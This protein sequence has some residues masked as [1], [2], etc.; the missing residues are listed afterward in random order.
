MTVLAAALIG[1]LTAAG[2]W[3]F[4]T[5][6][7]VRDDGGFPQTIDVE[8]NTAYTHRHGRVRE[9]G[10]YVILC[11]GNRH[12]VPSPPLADFTL[13]A[14]GD[15]ECHEPRGHVGFSVFF[16][17]DRDSRTGHELS[18]RRRDA[19]MKLHVELDGRELAVEPLPFGEGA[20]PI[21]LKLAVAGR[22]GELT[23]FGRNYAFDLPTDDPLPAR[24]SVGFD[25]LSHHG[26]KLAFARLA[27]S[28]PETPA[29]VSERTYRFSLGA[30]QGANEPLAYDVTLRRYA[31]GETDLSAVL[32]GSS[33]GRGERMDSGGSSVQYLG[34]WDRVTDPYVRIDTPDGEYRNLYNFPDLSFHGK[35][36]RFERGER[37][38]ELAALHRIR[39]AHQEIACSRP[40]VPKRQRH[41]LRRL[42]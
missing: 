12:F 26:K 14:D 1:V 7:A 31:T 4:E 37:Q 15:F 29:V 40:A 16:R 11:S 36:M 39:D 18:I 6:F 41:S 42:R 24:G 27:L 5:D 20:T 33:L 9:D 34:P 8:R 21:G 38:L 10:K 35:D 3:S 28:S 13:E 17:Y 23:V 19:D 25:V 30:E 32:S 2:G 22:H